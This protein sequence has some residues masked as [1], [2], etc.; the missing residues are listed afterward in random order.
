MRRW[1]ACW[2]G[3]SVAVGVVAGACGGHSVN[4]DGDR[5]G[6]VSDS[7]CPH[8]QTCRVAA[9]PLKPET[10][11]PCGGTNTHFTCKLDTDCGPG[12]YCQ[13][14]G[15]GSLCV[16]GCAASNANPCDDGFVCRDSGACEPLNC[17]DAGHPG[18]PTGMTCGIG[19]D[20][21]WA[22]LPASLHGTDQYS[23]T[24]LTD[25]QTKAIAAGCVFLACDESGAFDCAP[26]FRCD[27]AHATDNADGTGCVGIPCAEGVACTSAEF[28]CTPN[29]AYPHIARTDEHG[30][31][32]SN[33]D[34][35][36]ICPASS[37]CDFSEPSDGRGCTYHRCD[38]PG[39]ACSA[40][41]K[42]E[43]NPAP[44]PNGGKNPPDSSGC[45]SKTC[46]G[47]GI[48]CP[49]D[50]VCE[51][52]QP[53]ALFNG[54]FRPPPPMTGG[55]GGTAGSGGAGGLGGGPVGAGGTA[56]TGG[57][58]NTTGGTAG[59]GGATNATGG[60]AG[61]SDGDVVPFGVCE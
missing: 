33:C 11:P 28:V 50:S 35:G 48:A 22:Q 18:C 47:D 38:E 59:T 43:P 23:E 49:S 16:G 26:G 7:D 19:E 1:W 17:A 27:P 21:T 34:E 46:W 31:T 55:A 9:H 14:D 54:C 13:S 58:T 53:L 52:T 40:N 30:C 32:L 36:H 61:S 60:T 10:L 20:G 45:V 56:A 41:R 25:S 8:G 44:L 24:G 57:S 4:K 51:P 5:A 6:C 3:L 37:T 15:C 2:F 39:G 29:A 12:S 42:C